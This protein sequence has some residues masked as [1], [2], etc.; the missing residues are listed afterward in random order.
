[1]KYLFVDSLCTNR[2]D[3]LNYLNAG[4]YASPT[5]L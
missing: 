1:M 5:F 2:L 3:E 4:L